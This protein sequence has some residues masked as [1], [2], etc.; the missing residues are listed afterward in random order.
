VIQEPTAEEPASTVRRYPREPVSSLIAAFR[1]SRVAKARMRTTLR[2]QLS[3]FRALATSLVTPSAGET[4]IKPF[5]ACEM[6][7]AELVP[8]VAL[9][10]R[11]LWMD[12]TVKAVFT[13]DLMIYLD[14]LRMSF[15]IGCTLDIMYLR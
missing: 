10:A 14:L 3:R 13:N 6:D 5:A 7:D 12:R 4:S 1:R 11:C 9:S 2:T 8:I 15:I